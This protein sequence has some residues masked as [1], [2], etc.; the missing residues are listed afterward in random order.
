MNIKVE[1]QDDGFAMAATNEEGKSILMDA[2]EEIG[3]TNT[4]MRPMQVVLSGMGGCSAIDMLNIL[5]KQ[6]EPVTGLTVRLQADRSP[7]D[8]AS[9]F[10]KIHAIYEVHGSVSQAKAERAMR[11]SLDKYCS[12]SKMLEKTAEITGEI[13]IVD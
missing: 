2:S 13:R 1:L 4:G 12:V 8:G 7:L 5:R 6:K 10:S 9:V 11:L 3:G